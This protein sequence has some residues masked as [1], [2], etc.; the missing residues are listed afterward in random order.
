MREKLKEQYP[1]QYVAI[2]EGLVV[3]SDVNESSL[4][5]RF[6]RMYGNVPVYIDK[7]EEKRVIKVRSPRRI[8]P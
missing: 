7:P 3:D 5:G 6:Y 2:Y 8:K 1:G 4:I